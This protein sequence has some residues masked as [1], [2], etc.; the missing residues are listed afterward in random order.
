M[1]RV[2][3]AGLGKYVPDK[4]LSNHDLERMVD[5]SDEWIV[6][7]TGIRERRIA[8]RDETGAY[9]AKVAC[10]QV[11][12]GVGLTPEEVDVIVVGTASPDRLLPSQACDLQ[13][14]LGATNAAAFDVAAACSGFIYGLSVAEGMIASGQ[15]QHILVVG[16]ERLS[17]ITDYSDRTTCI[18]F[19]D[20]AGALVVR[21][22]DAPGILG[23]MLGADGSTAETLVIPAGG[24]NMPASPETVARRDHSIR[25]PAGRE[26][27]KRAVTEMAGACRQLLEKSGHTPADVSLLVPHQANARIMNAVAQ[28]LGIDP[29]HAV[30]DV[31]EVGNTSAASIPIA[32]DRAWRA[33]RVEPGDLVLLTSFGAGLSW[34]ANLMRWT[35]PKPAS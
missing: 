22:A 13:A 17:T 3:V 15:A 4:I 28:R 2:G 35:A 27:F 16:S 32:L 26:V 1:I 30:V 12:A 33:G 6:Q 10:E 9:M 11:L 23:S 21:P 8:E 34:G 31:A 24:A 19:G 25:M 5:T 18:L 29:E 14:V 20:G 7:R